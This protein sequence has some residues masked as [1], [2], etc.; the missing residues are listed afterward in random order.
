ML[1]EEINEVAHVYNWVAEVSQ[2]HARRIMYAG[3]VHGFRIETLPGY[4]ASTTS[5]DLGAKYRT[6]AYG[7]HGFSIFKTDILIG[8]SILVALRLLGF[9][10]RT[11]LII[12]VW[13]AGVVSAGGAQRYESGLRQ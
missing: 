7:V 6:G 12:S 2:R 11:G 10:F 5:M 9:P 13:G 8:N 1:G 3:S 4:M